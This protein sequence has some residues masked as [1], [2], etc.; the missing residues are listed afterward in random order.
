MTLE[1]SIIR[2]GEAHQTDVALNE[3][4]IAHGKLARVV[5]LAMSVNGKPLA[6]YSADG[7][8]VATPTGS[9]AYSLSAGGPLVH[10]SI[11][12]MVITPICPHSLTSRA[13]LAPDDAVLSFTVESSEDD[14]IQLTID[15]QRGIQVTCTDK[16][17]I[18]RSDAPAKL[19]TDIG[20]DTFYQKLQSKL[21]WSESLIY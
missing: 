19:I 15:G 11:P 20:G 1:S 16:I 6:C 17:V 13:L 18:K 2:N 9:T 4:V 8:I 12:T 5:R 7:I 10:P 3:I 21:H 14:I